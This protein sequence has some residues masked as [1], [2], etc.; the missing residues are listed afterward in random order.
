MSRIYLDTFHYDQ[1]NGSRDIDTIVSLVMIKFT[2]VIY[3]QWMTVF[4]Q[5]VIVDLPSAREIAPSPPVGP[6]KNF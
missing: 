6:R 3:S 2:V 4:K 5:H 1:Y